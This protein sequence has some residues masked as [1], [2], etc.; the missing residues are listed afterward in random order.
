MREGAEELVDALK[1]YLVPDGGWGY[2]DLDAKTYR[3]G[4][5]S[6]SFTTG[7]IVISLYTAEK[8]GIEVPAQ[9]LQ[10]ALTNL[11]RCRK[12]DGS[13]LYGLYMRFNPNHPV[14][15]LKGSVCR[16]S[17]CHLAQYL[18]NNK[19][20]KEDM[21][22]GVEAL[23]EQ[24]RFVDIARKRPIPHEGW[25]AT[26]GYFYLYGHFYASMVLQQLS[27]ED[28]Q[29]LSPSIK[30]LILR[31]QEPDGSWWDY[32]LYGYHKYYGTAYAV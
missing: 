20:A 4:G 7:T 29:R 13:Y 11:H 6:T 2:L 9:M 31:L 18:F 28:Q 8:V 30:E 12:E 10:K 3:P 17:C 22:K 27:K 16:T 15:K 32:P 1:L 19:V 5:H 14:N 21:A 24:N 25:Y 26:S 23:I